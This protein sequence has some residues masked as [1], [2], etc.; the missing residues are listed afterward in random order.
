EEMIRHSDDQSFALSEV[1]EYATA[2]NIVK[3]IVPINKPFS[4]MSIN[5][6]LKIASDALYDTALLEESILQIMSFKE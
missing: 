1:K 3:T 4:E 2:L 5:F 6:G